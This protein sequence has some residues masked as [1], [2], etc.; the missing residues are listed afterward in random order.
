MHRLWIILP[1]SDHAWRYLKNKRVHINFA[2][3]S[4]Y[5]KI[6]KHSTKFLDR[7]VFVLNSYD[8]CLLCPVFVFA[9]CLL[10]SQVQQIKYSDSDSEIFWFIR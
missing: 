8:V 9:N 1:A 4:I 3:A 5:I 10:C 2:I 7:F 6:Y